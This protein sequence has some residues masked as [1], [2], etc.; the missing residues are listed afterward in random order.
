M[1]IKTGYCSLLFFRDSFYRRYGLTP[2]NQVT[3]RYK[4][5]VQFG[6]YKST[7]RRI[8]N[9]KGFLLLVWAG[10]DSMYLNKYSQFI[11]DIK[12][13]QNVYHIAIGNFIANDLKNA[14][15]DYKEVPIVCIDNERIFKPEPIGNK[16]FVYGLDADPILYGKSIVDQVIERMP[17]VEF[18][19]LS[20]NGQNSVQKNKMPEVYAQCAVGLRPTIHDGLST[21]V[22][23][24]GLMGRKVITNNKTPNSISF[25]SVDDICNSI[26]QEL[27]R[28]GKIDTEI[29]KQVSEFINIGTDWLQI[30]KYK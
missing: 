5:L 20:A 11:H 2:Y 22:I 17:G 8:L 14:G 27:N 10:S 19:S 28:Y 9:H 13:K 30:E 15:I 16:V 7:Y 4:P 23:E 1:K 18:I 26:Q 3:D 24:M 29:A 12:E 25:S 21:S 6:C